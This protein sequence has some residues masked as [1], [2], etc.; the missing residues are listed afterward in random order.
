MS[1]G[2][3]YYDYHDYYDYGNEG[4]GK[5]NTCEM[6]QQVVDADGYSYQRTDN[7]RKIKVKDL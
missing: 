2:Y 5:L 1:I 6:I 4:V 3:Y 7:E